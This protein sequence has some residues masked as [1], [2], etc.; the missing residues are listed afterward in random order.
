[1]AIAE[2][3]IYSNNDKISVSTEPTQNAG[4][5]DLDVYCEIEG[6]VLYIDNDFEGIVP[7]A[8]SVS[9]GRHYIKLELPGYDDLGIW[10]TLKEKT[11]YDITFT[12]SGQI[13]LF[14]PK[15]RVSVSTVPTLNAGI[16]DFEV[17]CSIG[18]ATLYIDKDLIGNPLYTSSVTSTFTSTFTSSF[19]SSIPPGSH[20]FEISLP[21]YYDLGLWLSFE[22]RTKYTI[23]FDP[24]KITGRISINVLPAD[25]IVSLDGVTVKK[26]LVDTPVGSH[27]IGVRRFGYVEQDLPVVIRERE[28]SVLSIELDQAPF[29]IKGLAFGP[30]VF[31]PSNAGARG[32][33]SLNFQASNYGSAIAEIRGPDGNLVAT[34]DFPNIETWNQ[35][36]TWDGLG[37]NGKAL[38]DGVYTA[39]LTAKPAPDVPTRPEGQSDGT[40]LVKAEGQIDSSLVIRSFGTVSA[41]PGLL[42]MPD[43][44]SQPAGTV[45]VEASWFEPWGDP[46]ASAFGLSAALSIGGAV[47]L[48]FHAAAETGSPVNA[49]DVAG[50]A[51][52]PLFGDRSSSIG[53]A[54]FFRGS[55]SSA[56]TPATPGALS[57]VEASF[58]L[59]LRL[60]ELSFALAPGALVDLASSSPTFL[61][62]ARSGLWF[63][64]GSFRTG[65]SAELPLTFSGALPAPSWPARV[66]LEGRLMLGSTP[67]VASAY[68][69]SE[70]AP[71]TSPGFG[72]GL[73]LGL[74]F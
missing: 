63:E 48:A 30:A 58:P 18:G 36:R 52:V 57:A 51:L 12:P 60:G 67:F 19:T 13:P 6:G 65:I 68:L 66:A 35:S 29:A 11:K 69:D 38:P 3:P 7:F 70:L 39:T 62:L 25:A 28:T 14:A 49:T 34:L 2:P 53:G 22:E 61:G 32:R 21:G 37:P 73:G 42:Y 20:Y 15:D 9:T 16:S 41:V 24:V 8:G 44:L 55:Y 72:I 26:N 71:G 5:S 33:T 59:S 31:N 46:Q 4:L 10:L 74:L 45:A 54:L 40:I 56:S 47:T 50:S 27:T 43:P 23:I 1:M 64:E 17:D